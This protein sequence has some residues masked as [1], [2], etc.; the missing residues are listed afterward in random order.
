MPLLG[1]GHSLSARDQHPFFIS[2]HHFDSWS[3]TASL[4]THPV[5]P[6]FPRPQ[7]APPR[8]RL[9]V[10][11]DF[12]G[13]YSEKPEETTYTFNFWSLCDTFVYFSH[14][15]VTI[16]PS[17]WISAAH[18]QGV[19][20]LGTLIFEHQESEQDC[21]RL[22]FGR[23]PA[24]R[25]GPAVPPSVD[26]SQ[27]SISPH[28][29][30]LLAYIAYQR[31]FD[32]YLLNFEWHLNADG[33]IGQARALTAWI[34]LLRSELK[35]KVGPHAQV[36]W[37]DSVIFNGKVRWQDRLNSYNLPF[38]LPSTGFFTNYSWPPVYP[39]LTAQ[40]FSNL[41]P[42]LISTQSRTGASK[43][44]QDIHVGVDV[45]G[46]GSHG[47]GGFGSYRA[48]EHIDPE[49]LGLSVALF[50]PG[51]TWESIQDKQD[52]SWGMWW[53]A[54]RRLWIGP[55]ENA[56]VPPM[57]K[58]HEDEPDCL[59]GRFRPFLDFFVTRPPP[60][61]T[62]LPFCT[63]FSPGVGF[64]W[65]V[66][67]V[68]VMPH[69]KDGWTDVDKQSALGNMLWPRPKVQWEDRVGTTEPVPEASSALYFDDAWLGGN[70]LHVTFDAT[71]SDAEDAFFRCVWLP[72]QS[73]NVTPLVRYTA[74]V[75]FKSLP[76]VD[77]PV[78]IDVGLSIKG[79][80]SA[81]ELSAISAAE[82][83]PGRWTRQTLTFTLL[84]NQREEPITV[85][86]VV[87]FATEDP[88]KAVQFS[89][90]LGQ[91]AVYPAPPPSSPHLS[92][93]APRILWANFQRGEAGKSG[94]LTWEIA[95]TFPPISLPRTLP[96]VDSPIPLWSL[97]SS[98]HAFTSYS[99]FN[100]YAGAALG[101]PARATF[102]GTTGLDGR[103]NR[104][105]VDWEVL[106]DAIKHM[107]EVRFYVQGVTDR[108]EVIEW[109]QCAFVDAS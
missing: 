25:T 58:R 15:R 48:I 38:F 97:D 45:W 11:H 84:E 44:L 95:A 18:R 33:G 108:G 2:L 8:G 83:L 23:L 32:G 42:S 81:L 49:S 90:L 65:F 39:S 27:I 22:L 41:D 96:P 28:Y 86:L 109:E 99:Y 34:S 100:I 76:A 60:D 73:L 89:I 47:G 4:I 5:I 91:L 59:H 19:K 29:A 9:L 69:T 98:D 107:K 14:H 26:S 31:G 71:G 7:S 24:S 66:N 93:A 57:T 56:T 50:G 75:I 72:I 94:V 61:P 78:D 52:F 88:S 16:P 77:P 13:G 105:Y 92:V 104:F 53:E 102:I 80:G 74:H 63:S 79:P 35:A 64:A 46:R 20:I 30:R 43:T 40:F 17:G 10:C 12:K 51:W 3:D 37:Y 6:Y 87:G 67:G 82:D 21:L 62:L 55:P 70:G 101:G 36:I 54:E 1:K 85:G 103:A 68:V 106:P